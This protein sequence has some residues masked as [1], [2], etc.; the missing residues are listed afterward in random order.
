MKKSYTPE[1]RTWWSIKERCYNPKQR[2]FKYYGARGIKMCARWLESF[3]AFLTDMGPRPLGKKHEWTIERL[4]SKKDYCKENCKWL[5]RKY[6]SNNK[7]NNVYVNL[8]ET[9]ITLK[10]A[11]RRLEV[12]Y[13]TVHMRIK[14]GWASE[15]WFVPLIKGARSR[16]TQGYTS[17]A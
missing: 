2:A 3:P 4:D 11:C 12:P 1:Y 13:K 10:E 6:Q 15:H 8:E 7:S 5:E 17:H 16:V 9:T 14:C